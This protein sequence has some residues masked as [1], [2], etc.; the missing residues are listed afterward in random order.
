MPVENWSEEVAV[1]HLCDEPQFTEDMQAL[2]KS[3]AQRGRNV[4]LDLSAVHYVNSSNLARLLR[5]R[6]QVMAGKGRLVF[7]AVTTQVWGAFLITGLDKIFEFCDDVPTG[8]AALQLG[9]DTR[10]K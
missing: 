9:D 1:V 8:L 6:K 3:L 10:G 7:C 2:D 4:L 5:L